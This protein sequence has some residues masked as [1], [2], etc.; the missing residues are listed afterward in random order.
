MATSLWWCPDCGRYV[1]TNPCVTCRGMTLGFGIT[2]PNAP[3]LPLVLEI[4]RITWDDPN[5]TRLLSR[6]ERQRVL[7]R[8]E[9][10]RH[11]QRRSS[12]PQESL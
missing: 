3:F 9:G 1:S 2:D 8:G 12:G 11:R 6:K 7:E 5:M 10:H 4:D